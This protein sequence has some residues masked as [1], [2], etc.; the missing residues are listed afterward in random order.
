[1]LTAA[2]RRCAIGR[3]SMAACPARL[4]T[5]NRPAPCVCALLLPFASPGFAA[6]YHVATTGNDANPGSAAQPWATLQHAADSIAAGD[7]VYVHA[8]NYAGGH[9]TT[10]GTPSARI[11]LAAWPGDTPVV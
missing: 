11:L 10:P 2:N 6:T 5:M 8:G 9:F 4:P 3:A 7:T 1:M